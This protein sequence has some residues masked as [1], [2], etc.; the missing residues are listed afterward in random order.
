MADRAGVVGTPPITVEAYSSF[1]AL[2]VSLRA[3]L[4]EA[5]EG[6][7]FRS[8]DWFR[9]VLATSG[10][11]AD[12]P[13]I[14]AACRGERPAA[15]LIARERAN[16]GRLKTHM[17][18]GPSRGTY[19]S[20][21]APIL[22]RELGAA[23]MV[24]IARAIARASPPFDVLRFDGLDRHSPEFEALAAAFGKAGT[25]RQSF[26]NFFNFYD[27]ANGLTITRYLERRPPETR[28]FIEA[29]VRDLALSGRGR[30]ELITGAPDLKPALIDYAL[31][32]VQ[33]PNDQEVYP[34]C[35]AEIVRLAAN[36][37]LLRL[38]LLYIDGE[39]A[40]A[41][42]WIVSGGRATI[43]RSHHATRFFPLF[44]ETVLTYEM[45]R[46]ALDAGGIH[47]I[48]Y[49]P[50]F[51]NLLRDWFGGERERIGLLVF[52][53]RTAKGLIAAARHI[54]GHAVK[55]AARP[56]WSLLRRIVRRVR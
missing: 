35:A 36:A 25:L 28:S 46:H 18:L 41:Q 13:R 2:P 7:F 27:A 52:N 23:G 49:G 4:D 31:V 3:F 29:R 21:Y 30:F 10:P 40:A 48:E 15:V 50:G 8:V 11:S 12:T 54:G 17:L 51:D 32:D 39:P 16:A 44:V 43:W 38:G 14:Y 22:D 45:V 55:I 42:L 5:G 1:D 56:P 37:G 20:L 19:V 6:N 9:A 24:A 26:S 53:P 33:S 34:D 47:E